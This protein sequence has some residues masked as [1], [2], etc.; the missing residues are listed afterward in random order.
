MHNFKALLIKNT[1]EGEKKIMNNL[2]RNAALAFTLIFS[3]TLFMPS[4]GMFAAAIDTKPPVIGTVNAK[5]SYTTDENIVISA[6]VTDDTAVKSVK[7]Y[8]KEAKELSYRTLDMTKDE[9]ANTYTATLNHSEAWSKDLTWHIEAGDGINTSKTPDVDTAVSQKSDWDSEPPLLITEVMAYTDYKATH[10]GTDGM[11]FIELYNNSSKVVNFGYYKLYYEYPDNT[12]K[13]WRPS[14]PDIIIQPGKSLVLW[15]DNQNRSVSE[16]NSYYGTNL[17][18]NQDIVRI[19]YEGLHETDYRKLIIGRTID[20]PICQ[21][22]FNT[23]NKAES[24]P[25][26]RTT[27]N[28]RYPESG[29]TM[30]MKV[31]T[32]ELAP[33]PGKVYAWQIPEAPTSHTGYENA[34]ENNPP[35]IKTLASNPSSIDEGTDLK[36]GFDCTDAEDLLDFALYYRISGQQDFTKINLDTQAPDGHYYAVIPSDKFLAQDYIEYYV[37]GSDIFHHIKSSTY[38]VKVNNKDSGDEL[39]LNVNNGEVVSGKTTLTSASNFTPNDTSIF[40]DGKAATTYPSLESGAYFS[41]SY[42]GVDDYYKDAVTIGNEVLS[43]IT[44]EYLQPSRSV[45]LDRN[46]FTQN[47]DGS[48]G[49]TVTV[50]AGT[51]GSPFEDNDDA[52][53]DDFEATAFKLT[54]PG[55]EVIYP[56]NGIDPSKNYDIGDS[57]GMKPYLDIHFTIP[58]DKLNGNSFTWDTKTSADGDHT[59]KVVSGDMSKE[60]KVRVDNTAPNIDTGIKEGAQL[61]GNITFNPFITDI[62]GVD[63]SKTHAYLDGSEIKL[64]YNILSSSLLS[65]IHEL[66]VTAADKCGNTAESTTHFS[67]IAGTTIVNTSSDNNNLSVKVTDPKGSP[68]DLTFKEAYH[69]TTTG[70]S[71]KAYEGTGDYPL[72]DSKEITGNALDDMNSL[73][74]KAYDTTGSKELPYQRFEIKADNVK[75]T[76]RLEAV[77]NGRVND[78]RQPR[79]YVLNNDTNRWELIAVGEV[80]SKEQQLKGSFTA[81]KHVKGGKAQILVQDRLEGIGPQTDTTAPKGTYSDNWNPSTWNRS[82][83]PSQ[84]D[85]TFAWESDPQYYS[86]TY[87][88]NY[89]DMNQWIVDHSKELNTKYLI[90][91]GDIVDDWTMPYQWVNADNAMKVLDDAKLPYGVLG[92]NHDTGHGQD[93]YTNYGKYFGQQRF[94]GRDYYGGSYMNNK[95]HYDLL[96]EGGVDYIVLYMSWDIYTPEIQWMNEILAK[97][98]NRKAILCFHRYIDDKGNLDYTGDMVQKQVVAKNPNVFL[99]LNGH[100]SGSSIKTD[101]FDDNR[102]GIPERTVYQ[103]CTDYQSGPEGGDEYI[104]YLYFDI[105]NNKIYLNSYSPKLD[106]YNFF[107]E[108]GT[109]EN[110]TQDHDAFV[111]DVNLKPTE[112]KLSTDSFNVN[113]YTDNVIGSI[114]GVSSGNTASTM[115]DGLQSGKDYA[116]YVEANNFDAGDTISQVNEFTMK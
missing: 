9:K 85:F 20:N 67:V 107:D 58:R 57:K 78:G 10:G 90:N 30:E 7:L 63:D 111:L 72:A 88:Q 22:D 34:A 64:P 11:D 47:L 62:N 82:T 29:Q 41:L 109:Y 108:K 4:A 103:I 100:Y 106:D 59:I 50:R 37:E 5:T 42:S 101:K 86:K 61:F 55:G 113:V 46:R 75:S 2:K 32:K 77:W 105:Q 12:Y 79:M 24:T 114:K 89:I 40:I 69:Y 44:K 14:K 16:F 6:P 60:V 65:G 48:F 95:G 38:T 1:Q 49:I 110:G 74:N 31:S 91:T 104:K 68:T 27:V 99:V 84:Y 52:N 97:Y 25:N 18:E 26:P 70:G 76:D 94:D 98:S 73:D 15:V 43:M 66:K 19:N 87:P 80:I 92:G 21:V 53:N 81:D 35:Q 96:T 13:E 8:Y 116:W 93:D 83:R 3:E 17:T 33:T 54:L 23:D 112:K 36:L 51:Q 28:Y 115:W 45:Y 56:D 71:V 39:R 102:D